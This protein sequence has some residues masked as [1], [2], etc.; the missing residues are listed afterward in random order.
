MKKLPAS[1][2][3][4]LEGRKLD[5]VECILSDLPGIARGKAV[6]AAKFARQSSFFL[7]DS[8][9]FQTVTG[10]WSPSDNEDDFIE[11]DMTLVPDY[12]TRPPPLGQGIGHCKSFMMPLIAKGNRSPM[13]LEMFSKRWLIYIIALGW[14]PSLPQK[15]SFFLLREMSIRLS[16]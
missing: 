12:S 3:Q 2:V 14:N 11:R 7:P 8:I 16:R 13:P 4:Y 6:P 9:F 1:A 10:D 15:W 5:E